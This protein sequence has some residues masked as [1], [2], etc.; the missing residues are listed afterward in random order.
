MSLELQRTLLRAAVRHVQRPD[1]RG[2]KKEG[3]VY[4]LKCVADAYQRQG[5]YDISY[6]ARRLWRRIET[7]GTVA[8]VWKE[9]G[10]SA[11]Q[12]ASAASPAT[13][14]SNT[15]VTPAFVQKSIEEYVNG[16]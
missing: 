3:A 4:Y 12:N 8:L 1:F 9:L 15:G 5:R 13:P 14:A 2:D 16:N 10:L 6:Q 7:A 11:S